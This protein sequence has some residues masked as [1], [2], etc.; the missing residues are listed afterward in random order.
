LLIVSRCI[1]AYAIELLSLSHH[2]SPVIRLLFV[3]LLVTVFYLLERHRSWVEMRIFVPNGQRYGA[4]C[5][6][7]LIASD[8]MNPYDR[9]VYSHL[10]LDDL[11][12]VNS[13]LEL[14]SVRD[15]ALT[16]SGFSPDDVDSMISL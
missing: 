4:K 13:A 3:L 16:L 2:A 9:F 15:G 5:E 12:C 7:L 10:S 11:D 6:T 1:I 14:M 8:V